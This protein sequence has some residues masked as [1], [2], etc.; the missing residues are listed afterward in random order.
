MQDLK[1]QFPV[2][3]IH[4]RSIQSLCMTFRARVRI[5]GWNKQELIPIIVGNLRHYRI[6]LGI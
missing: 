5:T 6:S 1:E 3:I 4:G 2:E